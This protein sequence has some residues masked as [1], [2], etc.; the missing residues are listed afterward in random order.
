MRIGDSPQGPDSYADSKLRSWGRR[1]QVPVFGPNTCSGGCF[2]K[3]CLMLFANA[4]IPFASICPFWCSSTICSAVSVKPITSK[5]EPFSPSMPWLTEI[6]CCLSPVKQVSNWC[7]GIR[8][9]TPQTRRDEGYH[10]AQPC[11]EASI[12]QSRHTQGILRTVSGTRCSVS[13][14]LAV[15]GRCDTELACGNLRTPTYRCRCRCNLFRSL[16]LSS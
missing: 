1:E 12:S 5:V 7:S 3:S 14:R 16:R 15:P 10:P 8:S 4:F 9:R 13:H 6:P 2:Q 11:I